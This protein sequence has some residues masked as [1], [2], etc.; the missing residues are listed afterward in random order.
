MSPEVAIALIQVVSVTAVGVFA[1]WI[2]H[3][4]GKIN[5]QQL[6]ISKYRVKLDL[7]DRRWKVYERFEQYVRSAAKDFN[8]STNDILEFAHATQ[9]G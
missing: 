6:Q 7:Y 8:P 2:A 4:Q 9:P 1:A 3:Q 5:R